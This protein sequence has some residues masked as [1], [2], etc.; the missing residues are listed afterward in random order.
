MCQHVNLLPARVQVGTIA[1]GGG[2][3][4]TRLLSLLSLLRLVRMLRL[5]NTVK[6]GAHGGWAPHPAALLRHT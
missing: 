3:G 2:S 5:V 1:S 6:V 4:E